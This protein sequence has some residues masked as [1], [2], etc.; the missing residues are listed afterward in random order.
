MGESIQ[1]I[2]YSASG[3]LHLI[4]LL[5]S[6]AHKYLVISETLFKMHPKYQKLREN[7]RRF[8]SEREL[9]LSPRNS[10]TVSP[11]HPLPTPSP[12]P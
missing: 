8:R 12:P 1:D 9:V 4:C 11:S 5:N 2:A 10:R 3:R 7:K 6:G